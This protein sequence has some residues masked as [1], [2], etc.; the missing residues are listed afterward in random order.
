MTVIAPFASD[1]VVATGVK[2]RDRSIKT[3]TL[4]FSVDPFVR[5]CYPNPVSYLVHF[6]NFAETLGGKAFTCGSAYHS[7]EHLGAAL[8][9]P[10]HTLPDEKD[11]FEHFERTLDPPTTKTVLAVLNQM[12]RYQ[13]EE[14]H[15]Y[16]AFIGVDVSHQGQG[17]GSKLL[18]PMIDKFDHEEC[19][20][21]LESTNA[22][23]IPL[24]ERLGFNLIGCIEVDDCPPLFPMVRRPQVAG[25]PRS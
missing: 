3:L 9:L 10:P 19:L 5:F 12:D 8:W 11:V 6:P 13:P 24:Y 14:P 1:D 4:A 15:W 22:A 2:D 25:R 7:G 20:A 17:I 18:K 16:L 23:N 21:Y